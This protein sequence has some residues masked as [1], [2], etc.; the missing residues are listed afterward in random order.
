MVAKLCPLLVTKLTFCLLETDYFARFCNATGIPQFRGL[1]AQGKLSSTEH[2]YHSGI[3]P[4][5]RGAGSYPL[6][7]PLA[8]PITKLS[9]AT[10]S[11]LDLIVIGSAYQLHG[12]VH[13]LFSG[14][15]R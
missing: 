6:V 7:Q 14:S 4:C 5:E 13:S 8:P 3:P 11:M 12:L 1:G 10:G 15:S 9:I 2:Y